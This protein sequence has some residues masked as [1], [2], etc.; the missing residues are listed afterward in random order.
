MDNSSDH[1][2]KVYFQF[3]EAL[4]EFYGRLCHDLSRRS[5]TPTG[6]H[7][8][9]GQSPTFASPNGVATSGVTL[10]TGLDEERCDSRGSLPK[11]FGP[12]QDSAFQPPTSSSPSSKQDEFEHLRDQ[13]GKYCEKFLPTSQRAAFRQ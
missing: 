8:P 11:N 10:D 4:I 9:S 12:S 6:R 7:V 13:I 1:P 5:T 3:R 2:V